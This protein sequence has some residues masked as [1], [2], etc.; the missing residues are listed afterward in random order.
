[1]TI[2]EDAKA[3]NK[4]KCL[5]PRLTASPGRKMVK[6]SAQLDRSEIEMKVG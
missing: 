3:K 2:T 1:M 5:N 6:V 4:S